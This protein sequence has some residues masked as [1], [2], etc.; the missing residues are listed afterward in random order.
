MKPSMNR[1]AA[2]ALS[3]CLTVLALCATIP[4]CASSAGL[5]YT[6]FTLTATHEDGSP[7]SGFTTGKCTTLPVLLGSIVQERRVVEG[8]LVL[9]IHATRDVVD[10]DFEGA[11]AGTAGV[12]LDA[13]N[14][15]GH[16]IAVQSASGGQFIISVVAGCASK[17]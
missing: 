17:G 11:R 14:L 7:A 4:A 10:I 16:Q 6:A 8:S 9:V 13:D 15:G 3:C 12:T 1:M 2:A 5:S